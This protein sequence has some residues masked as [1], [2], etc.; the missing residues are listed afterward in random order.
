MSGRSIIQVLTAIVAMASTLTA[1]AQS[2]VFAGGAGGTL[3]D[4]GP[5]TPFP[6]TIT[7]SGISGA[8]GDL[9]VT[10]FSLSHALPA[11][12]DIVLLGPNG[13]AVMLLSDAGT[14][15]GISG[16]DLLF[17]D[18]AAPISPTAPL[19][20]MAL[21][22]GNHGAQ[23]DAFPAPYPGTAFDTDLSVFNGISPNGEWKLFIND[24]SPGGAGSLNSWVMQFQLDV[25]PE[26]STWIFGVVGFA[27]FF[28]R[29]LFR[30]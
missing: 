12:L 27:V 20:S 9:N 22:P 15:A 7:V 29:R 26:P 6:F 4:N 1:S 10:L 11:D 18:A 30:R 17:D 19:S 14:N 24:D 2:T 21:H 5:S 3:N 28:A 13:R 25:V 23:N 8:I 16:I